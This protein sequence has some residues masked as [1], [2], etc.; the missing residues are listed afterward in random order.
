LKP[1]DVVIPI[2]DAREVAIRCIESALRHLPDDVRLVLAD[3]ASRDPALIRFLDQ[4]AEKDPRAQLRRSERNVGFVGTCNAAMAAAGDRDVLLLNS[5]TVVTAGFLERLRECAYASP[6]TG[7]VCP[8]SNNATILSVP[9]FCEDNPVPPA[10]TIES[11]ADLIARVSARLRPEVV[12][13]VGFCMYV[14]AEVIARIGLFDEESFGRGY[15]EENDFCERAVAAGYR[16]RLAD[17]AF[18]FHRGGASFGA[19]TDERKRVGTEAMLRLHPDY[20]AKVARF[21]EANPLRQV[22]VGIELG[23]ERKNVAAPALLVLVHAPLD[24]PAGGSEHHVRDLLETLRLPRVVVAVPDQGGIS[25]SEVFDG[26]FAGAISYRFDLPARPERF[27]RTSSPIDDALTRICRAFGVGAVHIHHLLSWPLDVCRTFASLGLP[28]VLTTHDFYTLCPSHNLVNSTTGR[29]CCLAGN[30]TDPERRACIEELFRNLALPLREPALAFRDSHCRAAR[31]LLTGA[32]ALV[33]P[34]RAAERIFRG[35]AGSPPAASRVIPHGYAGT[36]LEPR[37]R[38]RDGRLQVAFLGEIAYKTKGAD[39][40]LELLRQCRSLDAVWHV[41]GNVGTFGYQTALE[42]VGLGDR[43][44]LHG[45]YERDAIRG[46]LRR[47]EIDIAVFLPTAP[48]TFSFTLSESLTA[49][50]PVLV[51]RS[52]ALPERVAESGAGLVVSDV[53][54]AAAALARLIEHRA[55]LEPL[56]AA[57]DRFRHRSL[58]EMAADY[59]RLYEEVFAVRAASDRTKSDQQKDGEA[60]TLIELRL[61][62]EHSGPPVHDRRMPGRAWLSHP[63]VRRAVK[64]II[65]QRIRRLLRPAVTAAGIPVASPAEGT[66]LRS[67][68]LEND[69]AMSDLR[70]KSRLHG[71]RRYQALSDDPTIVLPLTEP[72]DTARV[73]RIE[74]DLLVR[75]NGGRHAQLFWVHEESEHFSE[76]KSICVPLTADGRWRTYTVEIARSEKHDAWA[77]GARL[78]A[79]R[80]DPLDR[81]GVVSVGTLRFLA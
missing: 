40:V 56:R 29:P 48:E 20:F 2:H 52:G 42:R 59:R 76:R 47:H 36:A 16:I 14:R 66:V 12:T 21:I 60:R 61:A 3:D 78:R 74:F 5:D 7:I 45:A 30:P 18:V 22:H 9:R 23:L 11:F 64:Q 27:M 4:V 35:L 17:D 49:G 31:P 28:Y 69:R 53:A 24:R 26:D 73:R 41:F 10:H 77:A 62:A 58:E 13:G 70:P 38:R 65:P 80:F 81:P 75:G 1:V 34:S 19:E 54:E 44:L 72:I 50:V 79:L 57:A 8:L 67:L 63:L 43:L 46:L 55:E 68:S 6:D 51:N 32:Y 33:F 25:L 71:P 39:E 15:G 37:P